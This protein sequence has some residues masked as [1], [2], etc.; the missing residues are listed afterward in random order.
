MFSVSLAYLV[1]DS[2]SL[3]SPGLRAHFLSHQCAAD[4]ITRS[5]SGVLEDSGRGLYI[6][7]KRQE[8]LTKRCCVTSQKT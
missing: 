6:P 5:H 2:F 4:D 8:A 7:S 1:T 3:R